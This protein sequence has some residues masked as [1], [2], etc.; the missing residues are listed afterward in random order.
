MGEAILKIFQPLLESQHHFHM[1]F[2]YGTVIISEWQLGSSV[3]A[4]H[5]EQSSDRLKKEGFIIVD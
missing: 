4:E 2:H 1:E 3:A 5:L